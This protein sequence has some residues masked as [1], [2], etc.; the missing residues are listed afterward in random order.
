MDEKKQIK[1]QIIFLALT[2]LVI[3]GAI[4]WYVTDMGAKEAQKHIAPEIKIIIG[5]TTLVLNETGIV[6][7]NTFYHYDD[8]FKK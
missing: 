7:N 2:V 6:Y 8:I 3:G 1:I 4:C 5:K